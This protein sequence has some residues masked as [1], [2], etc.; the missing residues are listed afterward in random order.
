MQILNRSL[1]NHGLTVIDQIYRMEQS[2]AP[3]N[4]E[5]RSEWRDSYP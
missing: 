3:P 1:M 5:M 4:R 2:K